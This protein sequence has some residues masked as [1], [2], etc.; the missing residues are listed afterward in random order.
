[1][2]AETTHPLL[3]RLGDGWVT[4][5]RVRELAAG[6]GF[7][8]H[9]HAAIDAYLQSL[10]GAGMVEMRGDGRAQEKYR[11]VE[12]PPTAADRA[13]A[14]RRSLERLEREEHERAARA[15]TGP[16]NPLRAEVQALVDARVEALLREYGLLPT[17]GERSR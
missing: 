10:W 7:A 2:I 17:D 9:D 14:Q 4:L 13:E 3:D 1:M 16:P 8:A 6:L 12:N 5:S 15:V 11:R